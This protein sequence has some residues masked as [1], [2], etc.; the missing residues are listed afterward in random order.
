[1]QLSLASSSSVHPVGSNCT[2]VT[3][4][5]FARGI[6]RFAILAHSPFLLRRLKTIDRPERRERKAGDWG[7]I[8]SRERA[9]LVGRA[10]GAESPTH[11]KSRSSRSVRHDHRSCDQATAACQQPP[12]QSPGS[13]R[14][15]D[16]A[17]R[18]RA[19]R[20]SPT[21]V[22]WLMLFAVVTTTAGSVQGSAN[23]EGRCFASAAGAPVNIPLLGPYAGVS[24]LFRSPVSVAC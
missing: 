18:R 2:A 19:T 5:F 8:L 4:R 21:Q 9:Q 24:L 3:D 10:C 11:S 7:E 20:A 6:R 1:M 15:G 23:V 14:V 22:V 12:E 13:V 16:D 17:K